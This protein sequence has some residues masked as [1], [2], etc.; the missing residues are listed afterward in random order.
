MYTFAR[1]AISLT[2]EN[3]VEYDDLVEF[4]KAKLRGRYLACNPERRR[5]IEL[6]R[7]A[8]METV[9]RVAAV[10]EEKNKQEGA[11]CSRQ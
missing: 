7:C 2:E 1:R 3:K 11:P 5:V 6:L 8:D 4:Y 10:L 9:G